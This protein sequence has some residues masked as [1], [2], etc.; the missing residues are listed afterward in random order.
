MSDQTTVR[1]DEILASAKKIMEGFFSKLS[2][3]TIRSDSFG[4]Q[5]NTQTRQPRIVDKDQSY[6][7]KILNNAPLKNQDY[8]I[9]EKK[10]W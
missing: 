7:N 4:L 8:I 5:R 1:N 2:Q 10:T 3:E 9:A 6:K